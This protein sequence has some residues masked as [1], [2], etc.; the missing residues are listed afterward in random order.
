MQHTALDLGDMFS[1]DW[2][3]VAIA[4]LVRKGSGHLTQVRRFSCPSVQLFDL[5]R[6]KF[7]GICN[8]IGN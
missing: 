3:R 4:N 7:F 5:A 2:T 1:T 8:V 6:A